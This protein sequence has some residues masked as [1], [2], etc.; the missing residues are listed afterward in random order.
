MGFINDD[1]MIQAVKK[2]MDSELRAVEFFEKAMKKTADPGAK[3]MF[4]RL[5]GAKRQNFAFLDQALKSI[6]G[7]ELGEAT[8]ARFA[9]VRPQTE[10]VKL[11]DVQIKTDIDALEVG[12]QAQ[13]DQRKAFL[14]LSFSAT[15]PIVAAFFKNLATEEKYH[16]E[17]LEKQ[18][19]SIKEHGRWTW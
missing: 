10:P 8:R 18:Y 7:G 13:R 15:T 12:I 3:K 1:M 19:V 6:D 4:D 2:A 14:E 16:L 11:T 17:L 5:I 9:L